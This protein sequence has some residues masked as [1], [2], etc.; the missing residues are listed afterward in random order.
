MDGEN[1]LSPLLNVMS[2]GQHMPN[3]PL[4]QLRQTKIKISHFRRRQFGIQSH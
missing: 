2:L 1:Q 3:G 4:E